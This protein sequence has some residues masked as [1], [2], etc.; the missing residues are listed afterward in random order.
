VLYLAF[1]Q[2]SK[3]RYRPPTQSNRGIK[4]KRTNKKSY[5]K[6]GVEMVEYSR[7]KKGKIKW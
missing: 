1:G 7:R 2:S 4:R 3:T 6:N 5:V